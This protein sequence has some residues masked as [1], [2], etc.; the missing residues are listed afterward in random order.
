MNKAFPGLLLL[1]TTPA[2]LAASS[3][4]DAYYKADFSGGV[5]PADM[6]VADLSPTEVAQAYY[7]NGFT[8]DGWIVDRLGKQGYCAVCPTHDLSTAPRQSRM[9]TPV[10]EV[11]SADAYVRWQARSVVPDF[12]E[13]YRVMV[14]EEGK[15]T[16]DILFSTDSENGRW[17]T[18]VAPLS[19]YV[20]RRVSVIFETV[21]VNRYMLAVDNI[22]IGE[23]GDDSFYVED[24]TAQRF[25]G[26]DDVASVE[27]MAVNT[28]GRKEGAIIV[29]TDGA[30]NELSRQEVPGGAWETGQPVDFS[31]AA[32]PA[33]DEKMVYTVSV[34]MADGS[35]VKLA[36][37]TLFRSRYPRRHLVDK[38][39]GMW[40][41]NCPAGN[42]A[43]EEVEYTYG[44][45]ILSVETHAYPDKLE[46]PDYWKG[47]EFYSAPRFML[48]RDQAT[49]G[50]GTENFDKELFSPV[51]A[52][53]DLTGAK[54]SADGTSVEIEAE[55]EFA[56]GLDNT[57]DKW[58]IGYVVTRDYYDPSPTSGFY[59]E[60]S[61]PLFTADRY[62][63]LPKTILGDLVVFRNVSLTG[64]DAFEGVANSLPAVMEAGVPAVCRF[65]V[66]FPEAIEKPEQARI[67]AFI[68]DTTTGYVAN[69][70]EIRLSDYA[71]SPS[72]AADLQP[73]GVEIF[74]EASGKCV[75]RFGD[76]STTYRFQATAPD[77]RVLTAV[78]GQSLPEVEIDL[79]GLSGPVILS[80]SCD[81]GAAAIVKTVIR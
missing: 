2:G 60:N 17:V 1:L 10:F 13:A 48:N 65:T 56:D 9:T 76:G 54:A 51:T 42:L 59:Q 39:T 66:A 62:Y 5:I 53:I 20:G 4:S 44:D 67:V 80:V 78:S 64:K 28:G 77:G 49:S 15:D 70:A 25:I 41:N 11:V 50:S 63:F 36:D 22:Y 45:A 8:T 26:I 69:A 72:I 75:L 6:T 34:A 40:C 21:S 79:S 74:P 81:N 18:R 27:G 32:D 30:G 23:L 19:D 46:Q 61:S 29:L 14:L 38:G 35:T 24:L 12:P 7:K 37:G 3:V 47:L 31:L 52:R 57:A 33:L 43:L 16:P 58:R 68:L 71:D 73:A 55:A